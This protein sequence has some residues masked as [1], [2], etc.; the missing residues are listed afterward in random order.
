MY[1]GAFYAIISA[2]SVS[3]DVKTTLVRE[4][5]SAATAIKQAVMDT[6]T[7]SHPDSQDL[8]LLYA[9][10]LTD[11]NDTDD[12]STNFVVFKC[13]EQGIVGSPCGSG[14]TAPDGTAV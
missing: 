9:V 5:V 2:K 6:V 11:G 12:E 3:L 4:L 1:G 13:S 10:I 8:A 7:L 14:T